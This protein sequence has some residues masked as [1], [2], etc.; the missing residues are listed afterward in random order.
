[1][2][3]KASFTNVMLLQSKTFDIDMPEG[4]FK[5]ISNDGIIQF[6]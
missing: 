5:N 3:D 2:E 4:K 1:M 6:V